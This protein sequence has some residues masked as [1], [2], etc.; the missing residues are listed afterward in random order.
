MVRC[1][2]NLT[3]IS[4]NYDIYLSTILEIVCFSKLYA[5]GT[6][7]I[8]EISVAERKSE[9]GNLAVRLRDE[10]YRNGCR[11][12]WLERYWRDVR[13][14]CQQLQQDGKENNV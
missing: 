3:E 13:V 12:I 6:R 8:V 11:Y 14:S 9:M 7:C 4:S 1:H 2:L 5:N 10:L